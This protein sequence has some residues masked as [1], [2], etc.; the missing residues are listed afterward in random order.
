[1]IELANASIGYIPCRSAYAEGNYEVVSSRCAEGSGEMLVNAAITMLAEL[2][3]EASPTK[4]VA[5][6]N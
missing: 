5:Q 2:Y 4:A 3:N 6:Q 1:V